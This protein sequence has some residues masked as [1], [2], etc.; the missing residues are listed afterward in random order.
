LLSRK[1]KQSFVPRTNAR[2]DLAPVQRLALAGDHA[3]LEEL[4]HAVR[5]H[6]RVYPEVALAA[7]VEQ[8][9]VGDLADAHLQGGAVLDQLGDV[10]AD[11]ARHAADRGG[12]R[13]LQHRPVHLYDVAEPRHVNEGVPERARHAAVDEGQHRLGA[14][15]RRL[16]A[17]DADAERA[18]AVLVRR[19]DV[20]ERHV[21]RQLARADQPRDLGQVDRNEVRPA[22]V[23]G[24]AHV[25]AREQG[26][27]AEHALEAR[28]DV[29]GAAEREQVR[30][31]HPEQLAGAADQRAHELLGVAAAGVD[32][33]VVARPDRAHGRLGGRDAAPVR[34]APVH[35]HTTAAS[36]RSGS[37]GRPKLRARLSRR[38]RPS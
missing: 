14:L 10:R 33:N 21:Y 9:R 8:H 4:H 28:L 34:F 13:Q 38:Q 19:R 15:R 20:H 31:R 37:C 29:V 36:P 30:H 24:V 23:H 7:E 26:T 18:E 2:H 35:A 25:R 17:L 11:A 12:A 22:L 16:R 6:L 32:P 27:V 1:S 5:E 3:V